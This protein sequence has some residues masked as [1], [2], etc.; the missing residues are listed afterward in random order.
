MY[1]VYI[2]RSKRNGKLYTGFTEDLRKRVAKHR[3][4]G[5]YTTKRMSGVELIFYE[6]FINSRDARE[7]EKN[8]KTTKGKRTIRLMLKHVLAP[9]V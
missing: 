8:L 1:Y 6:A 4:N 5:V 3:A 2:L 9:V 7:R